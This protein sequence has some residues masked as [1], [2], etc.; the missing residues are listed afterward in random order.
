MR[1]AAA[2]PEVEAVQALPGVAHS[3]IVGPVAVADG[4]MEWLM[5]EHEIAQRQA[6]TTLGVR[7]PPGSLAALV[8]RDHGQ[9]LRQA[10]GVH[11]EGA[12]DDPEIEA[13]Q[14]ARAVMEQEHRGATA[15]RQP[16]SLL[17]D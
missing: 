10:T 8:Q 7:P 13:V 4:R 1:R 15:A 11:E 16:D 9:V 14:M 2:S 17:E 5:S 12:I 3:G 6:L